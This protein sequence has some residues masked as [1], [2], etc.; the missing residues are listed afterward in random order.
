MKPWRDKGLC[1]RG[2]MS[3]RF[4]VP[5]PADVWTPLDAFH[6]RSDAAT[7]LAQ[8]PDNVSIGLMAYRTA[9]N[10]TFV[11]CQEGTQECGV[12]ECG[13]YGVSIW[14]ACRRCFWATRL[15]KPNK[16]ETRRNKRLLNTSDQALRP[17]AIWKMCFGSLGDKIVVW[18]F[19][20]CFFSVLFNSCF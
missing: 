17:P 3:A 9:F 7:P 13:F 4:T 12:R 6:L 15:S 8:A 14:L 5:A 10:S 18:S 20:S 2:E 1:S 16:S 19:V 11:R